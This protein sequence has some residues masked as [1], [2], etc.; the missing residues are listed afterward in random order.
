MKEKIKEIHMAISWRYFSN[1]YFDKSPLWFKE[2]LE[3]T[4]NHSGFS[5]EEA[6]TLK[7]GLLDLSDRIKHVADSI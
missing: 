5:S 3:S 2:K 4:D 6:T 7:N 1:T